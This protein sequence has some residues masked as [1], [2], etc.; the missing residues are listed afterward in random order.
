MKTNVIL[1]STDRELFG[2][3][4]RQNTKN[5][6]LSITDLLKAYEVGRFE[7]GWGSK[8][9]NTLMR[10]D[11]FQK[12]VYFLLKERR[13]VKTSF[14]GFTINMKKDGIIGTFKKLGVWKS[15]G[16]YKNKMVVADPYIWVLIAMELNPLLYAKVVIWLTDTLIFDRIEAGDE[17]RP[18]NKAIS[19]IIKTPNYSRYA[20]AINKRVFG[21]HERGIRQLASSKQLR[22]ISD[23]EKF[24]TNT[25]EMGM[26]KSEKQVIQAIE[27][28][29]V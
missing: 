24:I 29:K 7:H 3:T 11:D 28:F 10:T 21:Q 19:K 16:G 17:Y 27:N 9:L 15:T 1:S 5:Q 2:V 18:M 25:I 6:M 20:M 12:R 26:I 4:V 23:I 8:D 22:K 13:L 14:D